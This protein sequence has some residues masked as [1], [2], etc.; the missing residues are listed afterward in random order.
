MEYNI[1]QVGVIKLQTPH[2]GLQY[3]DNIFHYTTDHR[4]RNFIPYSSSSPIHKYLLKF[5]YL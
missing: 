4:H 1:T 2:T 3:F 5:I